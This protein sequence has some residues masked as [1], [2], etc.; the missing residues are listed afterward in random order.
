MDA[1]EA[2][3][4]DTIRL[5]AYVTFVVRRA[6]SLAVTGTIDSFSVEGTNIPSAGQPVH[7]PIP[8]ELVSDSAGRLRDLVS[9]D[10][11]SCGSPAGTLLALAREALI[12]LPPDVRIGTTWSDSSSMTSCRGDIPIT[13]TSERRS[14][15]ERSSTEGERIRLHVRRESLTSVHGTG[16]RRIQSTTVTGTGSGWFEH[17]LDPV[18]GHLLGG[19]GESRLELIFD[20]ASR[21]MTFHQRVRH[22]VRRL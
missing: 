18:T 3:L 13:L 17:V 19:H 9:P 11:S 12:T 22:L 4:T 5:S 7:P 6:D 8:F 1:P 20:A 15:L 21:R 2:G 10:T 16:T 14:M